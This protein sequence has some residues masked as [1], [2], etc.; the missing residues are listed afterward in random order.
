MGN[1]ADWGQSMTAK[2]FL[3]NKTTAGLTLLILLAGLF[4]AA[5]RPMGGPWGAV[6]QTSRDAGFVLAD[7]KINGAVRTGKGQILATLDIDDGVP[8]LSIDLLTIQERLERIG[9]IKSVQLTRTLP[10][11]LQIDITERTPFALWQMDGG[12]SLIDP[13]GSVIT[14]RGLERI[15]RLYDGCR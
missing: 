11:G 7:L 14:N 3:L 2:S 6:V 13:E 15:Q 12:V 10:H 4:Y 5:V 9:W 1:Q 8:L